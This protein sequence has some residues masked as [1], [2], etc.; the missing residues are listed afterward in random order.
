M[1]KKP[2]E[3]VTIV[4]QGAGIVFLLAAA[5]DVLPMSD[6]QVIFIALACFIVSSMVKRI[7]SG[8]SCCCK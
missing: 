4:L 1:E 8:G 5:F 6:N 2:H 7:A 3:I